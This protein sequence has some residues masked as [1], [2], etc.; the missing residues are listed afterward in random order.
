MKLATEC[1]INIDKLQLIDNKVKCDNLNIRLNVF[2][3]D[4]KR[5][6][7]KAIESQVRITKQLR[8]RF[9]LKYS[10]RRK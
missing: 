10:I 7:N 2:N 3:I 8:M 1:I 6:Q 4:A 9:G 5:L